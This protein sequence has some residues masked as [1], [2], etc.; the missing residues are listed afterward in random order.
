MT[1]EEFDAIA[2]KKFP[3][4]AKQITDSDWKTIEYVYT[5]HPS[6]KEVDG[7]N[8]MVYLVKFGGMRVIK[9]MVQTA[10]E[11]EELEKK[12]SVARR[13]L[14]ELREQLEALAV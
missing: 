3:E 10:K 9:D 2:E 13:T 11:A 12:I 7:K 5:F 8:Q 1:R 4:V 14:N 6:I